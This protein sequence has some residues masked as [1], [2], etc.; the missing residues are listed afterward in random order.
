MKL[1]VLASAVVYCSHCTAKHT[2][3]TI[4]KAFQ[5]SLQVQ[6]ITDLLTFESSIISAADAQNVVNNPKLMKN[7]T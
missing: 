1:H 3:A 2:L 5:P 7:F 6:A 4:F